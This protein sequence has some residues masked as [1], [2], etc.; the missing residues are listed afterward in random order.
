MPLLHSVAFLLVSQTA[1]GFFLA[2]VFGLG[3]NGMAVYDYPAPEAKEAA[4]AN[5]LELQATTTRNVHDNWLVGWFM[6]G[7]HYQIEHH[8]FPTIPRNRLRD[9]AE[10]I[11][12]LCKKY[13]IRYHTTS[14]WEGTLEVLNFLDN[15]S[16][17]LYYDFPAM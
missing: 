9:A 7:L 10:V 13:N 16:K 14:M 5:F 8:L 15:V 1:C 12:P 11:R 17:E 3:H 2:I 6:G 4:P